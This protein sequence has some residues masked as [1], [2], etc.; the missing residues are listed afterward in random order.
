[1]FGVIFLSIHLQSKTFLV[2]GSLALGSYLTKITAEY[3]SD[4][5]GWPFALVLVGLML[6]G[7]AYL[8]L[9]LKRRYLNA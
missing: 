3:F 9:Q 1:M 6:M 5:L 8:A 4:S 2:F 7:V